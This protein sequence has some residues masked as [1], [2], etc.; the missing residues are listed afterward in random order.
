MASLWE[1]DDVLSHL[2]GGAQADDDNDYSAE[3][4]GLEL[5]DYLVGLRSRGALSAKDCCIIAFL[6]EKAGARG[7]VCSLAKKPQTPSGHFSRHIDS[8]LGCQPRDAEDWL[9]LDVPLFKRLDGCRTITKV[10][11]LP[12]HE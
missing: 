3:E 5:F 7:A 10:A 12:P 1:D 2:F 8:V 4:A 11:P 6:A 9:Y